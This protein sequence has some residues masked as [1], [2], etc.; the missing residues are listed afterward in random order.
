MNLTPNLGKRALY[1]WALG[2]IMT[3]I[4]Y[5]QLGPICGIGTMHSLSP[6]LRLL[7]HRGLNE[8]EVYS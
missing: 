6:I 5:M 2:R 8:A 3:C 1:G 4:A 7:L